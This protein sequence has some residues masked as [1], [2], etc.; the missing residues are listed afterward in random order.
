MIGTVIKQVTVFTHAIKA[1]FKE[2]VRGIQ[3]LLLPKKK[4]F[5]HYWKSQNSLTLS[6]EDFWPVPS[7]LL[8]VFRIKP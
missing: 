8:F 5:S 3:T 4:S 6:S 2:K 7:D 1:F